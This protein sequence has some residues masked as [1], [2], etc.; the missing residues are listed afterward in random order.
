MALQTCIGRLKARLQPSPE[1]QARRGPAPDFVAIMA[2]YGS[3]KAAR[4]EN[5]FRGSPKGLAKIEPRDIAFEHYGR[6]YTKREFDELADKAWPR[7]A[8]VL[9]ALGDGRVNRRVA[10]ILLHAPRGARSG[11]Q[12]AKTL[13]GEG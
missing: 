6:P 12:G 4:A 5:H 11:N 3:M 13:R 10:R 8:R 1:R 2:E 9:L 7:E